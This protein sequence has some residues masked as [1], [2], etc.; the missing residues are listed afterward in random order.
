MFDATQRSGTKIYPESL[1]DKPAP[2]WFAQEMARNR[3]TSSSIHL[4]SF[5]R[6]TVSLT[7]LPFLFLFEERHVQAF[8]VDILSFVRSPY[9][10]LNTHAAT[11]EA[12]IN[13]KLPQ[14]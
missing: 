11:R 9:C 5:P 8:G 7:T 1:E 4:L 12:K 13:N 14:S 3:S 6:L 2:Y 10:S